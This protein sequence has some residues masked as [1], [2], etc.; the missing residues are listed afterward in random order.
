MVSGDSKNLKS[1]PPS[2]FL[3]AIVSV[4]S[5][6]VREVVSEWELGLNK[7]QTVENAIYKS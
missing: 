5:Y 2:F 3:V 4:D 6:V 1:A 7:L